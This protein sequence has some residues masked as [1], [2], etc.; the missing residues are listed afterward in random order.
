LLFANNYKA[1]FD[2]INREVRNLFGKEIELG[3]G[4]NFRKVL[5]LKTLL[6]D[7]FSKPR[8]TYES[9]VLTSKLNIFFGV[10][11]IICFGLLFLHYAIPDTQE[12]IKLGAIIG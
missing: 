6:A 4:V 11:L 9:Q 8:I 7:T 10:I 5:Y 12:Q 1:E 2:S 3:S